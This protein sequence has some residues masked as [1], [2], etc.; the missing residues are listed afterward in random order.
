MQWRAAGQ[1]RNRPRAAVN[2]GDVEAERGQVVD[3]GYRRIVLLLGSGR[4]SGANAAGVTETEMLA[5]LA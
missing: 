3:E 1:A 4:G 5:F 2:D